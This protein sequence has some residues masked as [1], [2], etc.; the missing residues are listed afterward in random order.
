MDGSQ[1]PPSSSGYQGDAWQSM[2]TA[3]SDR[4]RALAP[5]PPPIQLGTM[6]PVVQPPAPLSQPVARS[7]SAGKQGSDGR[8]KG[9]K[10]S[11]ADATAYAWDDFST[12]RLLDVWTNLQVSAC[13]DL[14]TWL[15]NP[16]HDTS[17]EKFLSNYVIRAHRRA[18]ASP[19]GFGPPWK[20]AC[21]RKS[22]RRGTRHSRP[23]RSAKT[24]STTYGR[25]TLRLVYSLSD[26][27][28][29]AETQTDKMS[30][31]S[32]KQYFS[33]NTTGCADPPDDIKLLSTYFG[34]LPSVGK[35]PRTAGAG[36]FPMTPVSQGFDSQAEDDFLSDCDPAAVMTT[37][38]A[39]TTGVDA[40]AGLL[41][42]EHLRADMAA[43]AVADAATI[44]NQAAAGQ[45]LPPAPG[46][47]GAAGTVGAAVDTGDPA[48]AGTSASKAQH[49]RQG[50]VQPLNAVTMP[51][52]TR[53][54]AKKRPVSGLGTCKG[55]SQF[56]PAGSNIAQEA[57][58][59]LWHRLRRPDQPHRT[60]RRTASANLAGHAKSRGRHL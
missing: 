22:S 29:S 53:K 35:S 43:R 51:E 30:S 15:L 3:L 20:T 45:Q 60:T 12:K 33:E 1:P 55:V 39:R 19:A 48:S 7:R 5:P 40:G 17:A 18:R 50:A 47:S 25:N 37:P 38:G 28:L 16:F 49:A 24:S 44:P 31:L 26:I 21:R 42:E 36:A 8:Q 11:S 13:L 6:P 52:T 59:A 2:W 57:P 9:K 14:P 23:P 56:V 54:N 41:A 34:N 46:C 4:E 32:F 27:H 10:D 58:L